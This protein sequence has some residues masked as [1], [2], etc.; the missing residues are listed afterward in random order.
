VQ[1]VT[2]LG[3]MLKNNMYY[4]QIESNAEDKKQ[5]NINQ[6]RNASQRL[7]AIAVKRKQNKLHGS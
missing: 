6:Q 1:I 2:E 3:T 4:K 5:H 7:A